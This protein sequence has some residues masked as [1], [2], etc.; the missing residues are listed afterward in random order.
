VS[1]VKLILPNNWAT[2]RIDICF[3]KLFKLKDKVRM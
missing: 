1:G 2:L 3:I